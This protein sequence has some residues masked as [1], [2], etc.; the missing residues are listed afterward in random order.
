VNQPGAIPGTLFG[1]E[2]RADPL[3]TDDTTA[4]RLG[5]G[6]VLVTPV[7]LERIRAAGPGELEGV[8]RDVK[9]K[10]LPPLPSVRDLAREPLYVPPTPST[11]QEPP[12]EEEEPQ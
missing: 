12:R 6:P 1:L 3:L 2:I 9:L 8:L 4:V 7:L 11:P 10:Q 5:G